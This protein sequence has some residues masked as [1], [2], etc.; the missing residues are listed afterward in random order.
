MGVKRRMPIPKPP[1]PRPPKRHRMLSF[2][3]M[4]L[5]E[6]AEFAAQAA[7]YRG[8]KHCIEEFMAYMA[9]DPDAQCPRPVVR[10]YQHLR[11]A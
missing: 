11:R 3:D 1:P 5:V 4:G 2:A 10:R 8:L 9:Q 6:R 7:G